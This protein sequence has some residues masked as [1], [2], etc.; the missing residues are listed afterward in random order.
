MK[1]F[2]DPTYTRPDIKGDGGIRRVS[3]AQHKHLGKFGVETTLMVDEAKVVANH[4][5]ALTMKP[6]VPMVNHNHGLYWA[7]YR[8]DTW[9]D[10]VNARCIE[11]MKMSAAVTAPSYWV[12]SALTRGMMIWPEVVYH[13]VDAADFVVPKDAGDYVIWNKART[14]PV[15]SP[16]DL[17]RIAKILKN[18]K[19]ITTFGNQEPN[20]QVIG[21]VGYDQMK[22]LVSRAGVYLATTRETF[23][24]GTLEAMA[25]GVP[26]VG[27]NFGGQAEIIKNGETGILVRP[28]D[29]TALAEA[30]E[31][32]LSKRKKL[33]SAARLDVEKRWGWEKRVQQYAEIYQRVYDGWYMERPKVSVIVTCY[34]LEKYLEDTLDS[35]Q[36][37]SMRDYDVIIV[38][39]C[40]TDGSPKI[41]QDYAQKDHR[42]KY[43]RT[44]VNLGL[45]GARNFG[46]EHSNGKYII[47]LDADDMFAPNTL[48]VLS[49]QLDKERG[50]HIAYGHL[51]IVDDKG[52]NRHRNDW[53]FSEFSWR[54]QMAHMNQLPYSSMVRREVFENSGGYRVRAW[55][56]EDAN[57]WCRLT[58]FGYVAKKV[59]NAAMIIYRNRG[60]SKSKG[61]PG[62]GDW[63]AWYPWRIAGSIREARGQMANISSLKV[64]NPDIVPFGAQGK[65]PY[66]WKSW[67]VHDRSYPDVSII[68][69]VG[70]GHEGV[71]IDA[72]ESV[73]S[74]T[75]PGWE[76]IVVN[77]TGKKWEK[78]FKNP[79][80]GAPYARVIETKR[81]GAGA[82]RNAGA[83][84]AS[85]NLLLF[86]DADDMLLPP[87]IETML[88]YYKL[89]KGIIYCD[90]LR[91]DSDPSKPMTAYE[92]DEFECGAVLG[93]LR[94]SVTA[95]VPREGHEK[96]GG[97]DEKMEG[98]EDWD[99]YIALQTIGL[100]SYR[101]PEP[102]FV[103]RFREGTR[104]EQ[105]F[106]NKETL[107]QYIRDKYADYYERRKFMP[108][109]GCGKKRTPRTTKVATAKAAATQPAQVKDTPTVINL[110]YLGPHVGPVTIRGVVTGVEY[111]FGRSDSHKI[112]PV[113][114]RDAESLLARSKNGKPIFKQV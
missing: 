95:L 57:L 56:A 48:E 63:T 42:F 46:F 93:K 43:I 88:A 19:F 25:Y 11:S 52:D 8:W 24:I 70:P 114:S 4:G 53:P 21:A 80:A 26:V 106:D 103:Y 81:V 33:G 32:A 107:L 5:A 47:M 111:R 31:T 86:L 68:I 94:H 104:R 3:E 79:L 78:G 39:D 16:D 7:R 54:E 35:I 60:D 89:N 2:I 15:S 64:P 91:S 69:P 10:D 67:P 66:S 71:V 59:T 112:R 98:W 83:K 13:G 73:M 44:P 101:V 92:Q 87:A 74:Q 84:I 96:I 58:S 109:N 100:C 20:V 65:P 34:N 41:A 75:Y 77:D 37:Q 110:E 29:Y 62:D 45:S 51:D 40:S 6:N 14:D 9:A 97:F 27:W 28:G 55:R 23:G 90:W 36:K 82:A 85:A 17:N 49:G 102:L 22:E 72:V 30:I 50:I 108:C 38:D 12:A 18:R 113:D 76:V 99:Y 61:E 105:S 1:V